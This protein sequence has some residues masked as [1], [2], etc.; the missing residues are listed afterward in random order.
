MPTSGELQT[1]W[2]KERFYSGIINF[3]VTYKQVNL[4]LFTQIWVKVVIKVCRFVCTE[5][6]HSLWAKWQVR[7][8]SET[9]EVAINKP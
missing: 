4:I 2:L 9:H 5:P 8:A 1:H 7:P 6:K 3:K